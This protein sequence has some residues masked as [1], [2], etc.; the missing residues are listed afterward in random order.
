[1][2]LHFIFIFDIFI[3]IY[4]IYKLII[5]NF[6]KSTDLF[7][8]KIYN[9]N[10]SLVIVFFY[11]AIFVSLLYVYRIFTLGKKINLRYGYDY[12]FTYFQLDIPITFKV[13]FSIITLLLLFLLI[14]ILIS[15]HTYSCLEFYKIFIFINYKEFLGQNS[16]TKKL[17]NYMGSVI[18][19][20]NI[21]IF[22]PN[23][24][25]Y[26]LAC[27]MQ[28][29]Y[30]NQGY[31]SIELPSFKIWNIIGIIQNHHFLGR[32]GF[33]YTIDVVLYFGIPLILVV[34]ECIFNNFILTYIFYYLLFIIPVKLFQ[35]LTKTISLSDTYIQNLM[36][37]I[38]YKNQPAVYV[39][40]S[41][42][43]TVLNY[44]LLN[45]LKKPFE[46][47]FNSLCINETLYVINMTPLEFT[48]HDEN[49]AIYINVYGDLIKELSHQQFY[50][51]SNNE[52]YTE[53]SIFNMADKA[54]FLVDKR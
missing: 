48:L 36:W 20:S 51:I 44:F 17:Y 31:K 10:L 38:Y 49:L 7:Q 28:E 1:M 42:Q 54:I 45:G 6:T 18:N 9:F 26:K 39:C 12:I 41:V 14:L 34:Y 46:L 4:F 5:L 13:Y 47:G 11:I 30:L 25:C 40:T 19:T 22:L 8:Y 43:Q 27:F 15:I 35:R 2:I 23:Q 32:K 21:I 24:F 29:M 53:K 50:F 33:L 16:Y 3:L 52:D 37:E